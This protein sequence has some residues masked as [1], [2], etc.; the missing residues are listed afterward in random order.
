MCSNSILIILGTNVL[1][2]RSVQYTEFHALSYFLEK[3]MTQNQKS[4]KS[5]V[6]CHSGPIWLVPA[7][8]PLN[9]PVHLLVKSWL[10]NPKLEGHD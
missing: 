1:S 4:E 6:I 3:F 10:K 2:A 8:D 7:T 9:A 5:V